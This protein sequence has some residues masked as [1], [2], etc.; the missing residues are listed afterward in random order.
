MKIVSLDQNTPEWLQWRIKHVTAT[1]AP[2]IL[3]LDRWTGIHDHW[4][5]KMG[6]I[7]P[8]PV[9]EF[10]KRGTALEPVAR[11]LLCEQLDIH[12]E[13]VVIESD[14]YPWMGASLDG[15][16]PDRS[17]ICEIKCMKLNK[18][19]QVSEDNIDPCHYAQMQ[20][21]LACSGAKLAVYASYHP[22]APETLTM[23]QIYPNK[24]YIENMIE[25]EKE[26]YFE[27]MCNMQ[28]TRESFT[29]KQRIR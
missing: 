25:K 26:F 29:L 24:E 21:Q 28:P 6:F 5:K 17:A 3:G 4:M 1:D 13:P 23:I 18:H 9:N 8:E 15:I 12:F 10:M 11:Q 2:K 27:T 16:S 19:L 22:D 7:E 20:H 14:Q